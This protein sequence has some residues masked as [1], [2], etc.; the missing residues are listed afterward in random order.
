MKRAVALLAICF[1]GSNAV[2]G[3]E[4]PQT[5]VLRKD[6]ED[7]RRA[8]FNDRRERASDG[9]VQ[10]LGRDLARKHGSRS[11][12]W[13]EDC[14]LTGT[15]DGCR[16]IAALTLANLAGNKA[17]EEALSRLA[18]HDTNGYVR[19]SA[20]DALSLIDAEPAQRLLKELVVDPRAKQVHVSCVE[21][22]CVRGDSS[23]RDLLISLKSGRISTYILAAMS[24]WMPVLDHKLLLPADE[25]KEWEGLALAYWREIAL[26]QQRDLH[27]G[28]ADAAARG[29]ALRCPRISLP[30]LRMRLSVLDPVAALVV[31]HLKKAEALKDLKPAL[32]ARGEFG[33]A[34]RGGVQLIGTDEA[35]RALELAIQGDNPVG[36][37]EDLAEQLAKCGDRISANYLGRLA[38]DL[39]FDDNA[40]GAFKRSAERILNRLG[41]K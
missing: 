4:Q 11:A 9:V 33:E 21:L 17:A 18:C 6:L 26:A 12:A 32:R 13:L 38:E 14:V 39:R 10:R 30:F 5:D 28:G 29:I 36:I 16:D 20:V 1:A 31:G 8:M 23:A 7:A 3:Q 19:R 24:S 25:A 2:E 22:L 15:P 41:P 35:A 37:N 27:V 34:A 40:R